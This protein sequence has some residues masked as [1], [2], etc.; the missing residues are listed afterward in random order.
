MPDQ[1]HHPANR[2]EAPDR[3]GDRVRGVLFV[4]KDGY[5]FLRQPKNNYLSGPGDVYVPKNVIQ[6][7]RIR[8]GSEVEG[9]LGRGRRGKKKRPL[10]VVSSING[11]PP[12]EHGRT[13]QFK[14][15]PATDPDRRVRLEVRSNDLTLRV[16]D[17]VA[18]IGFGQRGLIVGAPGTGKTILLEKIAN[19]VAENHPAARVLV[20]LCDERPEEITHFRRACPRA[21]VIASSL[22]QEPA[23]HVT[24]SEVV[25]DRARRLG[26]SGKD[27][28]ILIDSLTRVARAFNAERGRGGRTVPSGLD[29][30]SL[31]KPR[32]IMA[33]ARH[34][35]RG[36]SLTVLATLLTESGSKLDQAVYDELKNAGTAE[37]VLSRE[38]ADK[39]LFPAIDTKASGTRKEEKLRASD[40][41]RLVSTLRRQLIRHSPQKALEFILERLKQT[42]NNAE[43]LL[44]LHK[45]TI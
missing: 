38:L 13:R 23:D 9:V 29:A 19:A 27:V 26:E 15:L 32:E 5:G 18:P 12:E 6:R 36:G 35:D 14:D 42:Q 17:L 8:P 22:E 31:Q 30:G 21:E 10:E 11:R 41:M 45:A 16:L 4:V 25:L 34:T 28:F 3:E 1:P 24:V 44:Q 40:E 7:Y 39:R 20:L 2:R 37:I 33:S 43:F